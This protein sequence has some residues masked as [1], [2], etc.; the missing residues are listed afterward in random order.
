MKIEV[1]GSGCAKCVM[2]EEMVK[3][4]VKKLGIKAEVTHIYDI[5]K[6]AECGVMMTPAILIDGEIMLEGKVPNEKEVEG[7]LKLK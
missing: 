4:V 7:I 3:K 6:I 1:L 5:G 2:T